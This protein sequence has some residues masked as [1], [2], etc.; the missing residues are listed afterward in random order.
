MEEKRER[1]GGNHRLLSPLLLPML[2]VLATAG[3]VVSLL[4]SSLAHLAFSCG[5]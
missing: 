2:L 5:I 4:L 1:G 3:L